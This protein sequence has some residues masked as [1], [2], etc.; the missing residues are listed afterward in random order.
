V[1]QAYLIVLV[2]IGL[3]GIVASVRAGD[4]S[5]REIEFIECSVSKKKR[6][7]SAEIV[8]KPGYLHPGV[9]RRTSPGI[10]RYTKAD[11]IASGAVGHG[12]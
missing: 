9:L 5:A 4:N 10:A 2:E 8:V 12:R 1:H 11:G 6:G 7:V 3:P